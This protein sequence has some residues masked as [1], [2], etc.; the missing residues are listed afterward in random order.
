[1]SSVLDSDFVPGLAGFPDFGV[2][3]WTRSVS[4]FESLPTTIAF[5]RPS[6]KGLTGRNDGGS[7]IPRPVDGTVAQ[8]LKVRSKT[9]ENDRGR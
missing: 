4:F 3:S 8:A 9:R 7:T 6:I 1:M 2:S 5:P